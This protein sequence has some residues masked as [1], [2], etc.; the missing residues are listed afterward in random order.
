MK[1]ETPKKFMHKLNRFPDRFFKVEHTPKVKPVSRRKRKSMAR[2]KL[3]IVSCFLP[4]SDFR[5]PFPVS[6]DPLTL[7]YHHLH[8]SSSPNSSTCHT[9]SLS[10]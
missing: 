5:P 7:P 6:L 8:L 9:R 2:T 4:T 3:S 10:L 1:I